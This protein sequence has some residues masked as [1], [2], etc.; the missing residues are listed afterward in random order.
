MV[1]YILYIDQCGHIVNSG[2]VLYIHGYVGYSG[3]HVSIQVYAHVY[4]PGIYI[5]LC[6]YITFYI[7]VFNIMKNAIPLFG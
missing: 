5:L 3:T 7:L 2:G 1:E 6:L 4:I